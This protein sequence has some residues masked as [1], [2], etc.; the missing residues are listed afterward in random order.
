MTEA[1][2]A[3]E[4]LLQSASAA[5]QPFAPNSRYY[6]LPTLSLALPDGTTRAY[7]ARRFVPRPERFA[8]LSEHLVAQDDRLDSLAARYFG[9]PVLFWRLCDANRALRP[10]ELI[11]TVGR[12]LRITLPE[13]VPFG[14][15]GR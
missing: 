10:D 3:L 1:L 11:E 5:P 14:S 13:G 7:L 8:F 9:D 4:A 12:A 2:K 6:G 15:G